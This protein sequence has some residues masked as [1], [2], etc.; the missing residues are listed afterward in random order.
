MPD[1]LQEFVRKV[2]GLKDLDPKFPEVEVQS[3]ELPGKQFNFGQ[4]NSRIDFVIAFGVF[5]QR[6]VLWTL[7][8]IRVLY[9][10]ELVRLR[11][12]A[13]G[14]YPGCLLSFQFFLPQLQI[15]YPNTNR[16]RARMTI[17]LQPSKQA[18]KSG[19]NAETAARAQTRV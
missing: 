2:N 17:G 19:P 18:E 11:F 7:N 10:V 1:N 9:F 3:M 16:A 13:R 5:Y 6:A 12:I 14:R 15:H 8:S 4:G